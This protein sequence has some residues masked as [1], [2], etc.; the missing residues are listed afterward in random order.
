MSTASIFTSTIANSL[1]LT[2]NKVIDD[3]LDGYEKKSM[4]TKWCDIEEMD[5]NWVDD[6][7]M[8]GPGLLSEKAEGGEMSVGSIQEGVITRYLSRTFAQKLI[9]TEEAMEDRKYPQVLEAAR[10]LK[11]AGWKTADVDSTFML[12]RATNTSYVG[13]DAQPLASTAHT[14][15]AGGTYSNKMTVPAS[16]SR[17]AVAQLMSQAKKLPGHD[18]I[19]EGY[20][21][22]CVLCPVEQW[23]VWEG[24]TKS[25]KAPEPGAFNEINVVKG[26][27][28]DVYPLPFWSNTTTNWAV[29]TDADNGPKFKWRRKFR[30]RTWVDNDQELMKY[31][32]SARWSRGWSDARGI[33]FVDA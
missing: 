24:L 12:I 29:K 9:I 1:K 25:E 20:G 32:L 31:G 17:I 13:G 21:F 33:L 2:L 26:M 7:E 4:F 11:R 5:D 8:G 27:F 18:S 22:K 6:L 3:D 30:S 19:T 14:L 28:E 15:P 10:R 23:Y 16:P